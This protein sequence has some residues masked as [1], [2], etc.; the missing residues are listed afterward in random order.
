MENVPGS[1]KYTLTLL[2]RFFYY[3][4][5]YYRNLNSCVICNTTE[6]LMQRQHSHQSKETQRTPLTYLED[7]EGALE[8]TTDLAIAIGRFLLQQGL[9]VVEYDFAVEIIM[10]LGSLLGLVPPFPNSRRP[11]GGHTPRRFVQFLFDYLFHFHHGR[12]FTFLPNGGS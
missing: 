7:P 1:K 9:L 3:Y 5:I 6:T 2:I 12:G 8:D 4:I 11:H 10:A